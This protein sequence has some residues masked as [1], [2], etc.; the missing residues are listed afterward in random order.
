MNF[1]NRL[2][3]DELR[4]KQKCLVFLAHSVGVPC[5][6]SDGENVT[7]RVGASTDGA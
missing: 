1:E 4:A 2:S 5:T 7:V 6:Y 3:F